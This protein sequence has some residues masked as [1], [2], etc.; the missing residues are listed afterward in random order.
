MTYKVTWYNCPP[1]GRPADRELD[2]E[3][4]LN[5]AEKEFCPLCECFNGH[6]FSCVKVNGEYL[7]NEDDGNPRAL[8]KE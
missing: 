7:E 2:F 5:A 1:V 3:F 6:S 4:I 8:P